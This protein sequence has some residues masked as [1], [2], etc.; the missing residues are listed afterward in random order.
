MTGYHENHMIPDSLSEVRQDLE[1]A[2]VAQGLERY[3]DL[4]MAAG[5]PVIFLI[6]EREGKP[7]DLLP[8]LVQRFPQFDGDKA[9]ALVGWRRHL[10]MLEL[11]LGCSRIGGW[12]DLPAPIP[13]PMNS[14]GEKLQLAAQ[15]NLAELPKV[16]GHPFPERGG[17][18]IFVDNP[19]RQFPLLHQVLH[20]DGPVDTLIRPPEPT[21]SELAP[22][23]IDRR[24]L[25]DVRPIKEAKL[26]FILPDPDEEGF[27]VLKPV[28]N[29]P[30]AVDRYLH[31][32]TIKPRAGQIFG[33]GGIDGRNPPTEFGSKAGNDWMLLMWLKG[34]KVR[35]SWL[36][37]QS[38]QIY[39]RRSDL[40]RQDFSDCYA[41][42]HP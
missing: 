9:A 11:P 4:L 23:Y 20:Y 2:I 13:W 12:P 28:Y 24:E 40:E 42:T 33:P 35:V 8:A 16:P 39:I 37:D 10:R 14:L 5:R 7:Q 30:D 3:H 25:L 21:A 18:Y 36:G 19:T 41:T 17:L 32:P 29:D 22:D 15:L 1:A 34:D 31:F 26:S 6:N 27:D 38:L